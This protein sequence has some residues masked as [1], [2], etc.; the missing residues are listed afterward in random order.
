MIVLTPWGFMSQNV[1]LINILG[2][3]ELRG[4][5]HSFCDRGSTQQCEYHSQCEYYTQCEGNQQ[6]DLPQRSITDNKFYE[7]KKQWD[8]A[9]H[10]TCHMRM[11]RVDM[12]GQTSPLILYL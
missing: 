1:C 2:L 3:K 12:V 4:V 7:L 6:L 9:S 11:T 5:G 8:I 10:P